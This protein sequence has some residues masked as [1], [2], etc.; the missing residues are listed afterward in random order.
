MDNMAVTILALYLLIPG[1]R[2][3]KLLMKLKKRSLM[4]VSIQAIV[5]AMLRSVSC[6]RLRLIFDGR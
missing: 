5:A 2:A 1:F 6:M 4:S 3:Q